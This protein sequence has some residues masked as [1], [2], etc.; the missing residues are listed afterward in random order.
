[1][2]L[3]VTSTSSEMFLRVTFLSTY[4]QGTIGKINYSI[5]ILK[6]GLGFL[7]ESYEDVFVDHDKMT[8]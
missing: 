3:S 8:S 4:F 5:L 7:N 1:M 2:K 6:L